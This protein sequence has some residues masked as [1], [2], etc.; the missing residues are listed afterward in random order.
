MKS[1]VGAF[2]KAASNAYKMLS[3]E[4]RE[5]L[6]GRADNTETID[7]TSGNVIKRAAAVFKKLEIRFKH[8]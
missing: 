6:Q 2:N 7:T 1:G 3:K 4:E 8:K 5:A